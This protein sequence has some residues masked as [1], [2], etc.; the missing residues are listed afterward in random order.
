LK[1]IK[2]GFIF[3]SVL[4]LLT[5]PS[6]SQT[7]YAAQ[8]KS[9]SI[10]RL[11]NKLQV[12]LQFDRLLEYKSFVLSNPNRLA[13]DFYQVRSFDSDPVTEVVDYGVIRIRVGKNRPDVTRVVFDLAERIP[14][15]AIERK[16]LNSLIIDFWLEETVEEK[17][18]IKEIKPPEKIPPEVPEKIVKKE[19]TPPPAP[20]PAVYQEAKITDEEAM[21]ISLGVQA[22]GYFPHSSRLQETYQT[23]IFCLGGE[24]QFNF[25]FRMK[26]FIGV[27][28][29]FTHVKSDGNTENPDSRIRLT[30]I[31]LSAL[32]MRKFSSF[33][34]FLGI[35]I[36]Y[37]NYSETSPQKFD[38][39]LYSK[40]TWGAN[41]Q[42]GALVK[43][44]SSFSL[45]A[46]MKYHSARF[47]EDDLNI[48]LGGNEYGLVIFYSFNL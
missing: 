42:I 11:E 7:Q 14:Y 16:D 32:Y 45:K 34:P 21:T 33:Y 38:A 43:V 1:A 39:P 25:P 24:V 15:F 8:L 28:L 13:I 30:P 23:G 27:S 12:T 17:P 36:D 19:E 20:T 40:Y 10:Q 3:L 22:G 29:G 2:S 6:L 18:A 26:E 41:V 31:S 44:A 35:G 4:I 47:K 48:N 46:Y 37:F 5:V 9:I